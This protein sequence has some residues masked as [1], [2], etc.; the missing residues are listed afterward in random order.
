MSAVFKN[1]VKP[2]VGNTYTTIYEATQKTAYIIECDIACITASGVQVSVKLKKSNPNVEAHV[3]KDVPIPPGST[4]QVINGQK[5]VLEVGDSLEA[6]CET[7]GATVDVIV[8]LVDGVN[9]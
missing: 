6:K 4:I 1:S 2:S 3:V 8:S 5:L 7:S 9:D